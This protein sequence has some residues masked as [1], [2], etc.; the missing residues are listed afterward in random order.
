MCRN[1]SELDF[2]DK[3]NADIEKLPPAERDAMRKQ[4][5]EEFNMYLERGLQACT[6]QCISAN[7]TDDMDCVIAAKTAKQARACMTK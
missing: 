2:W 4:K 5:A 1:Y 3:A 7:N 6:S